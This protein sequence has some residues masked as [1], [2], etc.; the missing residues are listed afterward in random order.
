MCDPRYLYPIAGVVIAALGALP[1]L[2][3]KDPVYLNRVGNLVIGIGVWMSMRYTL[4]E[5]ISK[6]KDTMDSSPVAPGTSELNLEFFNRVA[7]AIGDAKL[8]LHGFGLV[9]VG[10]IVGSYGDLIL[11]CLLPSLG[12]K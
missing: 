11:R 7:F 8:Q 3:S 9:A 1:A 6:Y 5:G 10:S 4:R 12:W 2:V